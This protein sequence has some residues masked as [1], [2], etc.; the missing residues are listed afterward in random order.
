MKQSAEAGFV[1]KYNVGFAVESLN[2]LTDIM[3]DM[4]EEKYFDIVKM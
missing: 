2:E 1:E 3:S 4:T